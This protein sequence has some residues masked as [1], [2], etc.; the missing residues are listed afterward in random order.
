MNTRFYFATCQFGAEK[1][2]TEEILREFPYLRF[3]FSRPGFITFKEIV[4]DQKP[5][6]TRTH[7]IFA[8]LWGSSIGQAKDQAALEALIATLPEDATIHTFERDTF[9]PGDEPKGFVLNARIDQ[10][11]K[12]LNIKRAWN[13]Q[14]KVGDTVYDLI[15][16]DDFYVFLG[17]HIHGTHLYPIRGNQPHIT[18]P[19]NSPSRAYLKIMEAIHRFQ[20]RIEKGMQ[21]LE[22]GCSP[23]GATTAMLSLGLRVTGIDPKR[24]DSSLYSKPNFQFI[25]TLAAQITEQDL[26][27]V[28]PDW[29]VM[30]MNIAPLEA[31]DELTHVLNCLKKSWGPR[32]KLQN[33]FLTLKLNDWKF[34]NSIPLYL[35]RLEQN[36]FSDLIP[37][38][39]CSNR[40]E[41]FV[42]AQF[43][44]IAR[45]IYPKISPKTY[46][47]ALRT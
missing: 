35:K 2:T 25:Q 32:L 47:K 34:A 8:R 39:L 33:G 31:L 41:F 46:P 20:P 9:V 10:I 44:P 18:L 42:M 21:V 15:W 30:D 17:S 6:I 36:G 3:A 26:R 24:M 27:Q 19:E 43:K 14:P 7:S 11:I 38:Q 29:I 4:N 22:I 5:V 12:N 40:Q 37:I 45:K 23:G 16:I 28:N 1:A 13:K